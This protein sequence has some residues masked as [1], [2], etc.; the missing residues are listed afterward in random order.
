V[1]KA[2][3]NRMLMRLHVQAAQDRII[4]ENQAF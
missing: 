2:K 3:R 1:G 4:L